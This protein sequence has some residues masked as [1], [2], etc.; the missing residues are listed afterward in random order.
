MPT[1]SPQLPFYNSMLR[2]HSII[3]RGLEITHTHSLQFSQNGFPNQSTQ[4][5]FSR[6][7]HCLLVVLENHHQMEEEI[8]FP[9][10]QD[11][12][13]SLRIEP[14]IEQHKQMK[15]H[16]HAVKTALE[17][18]NT[19]LSPTESLSQLADASSKLNILWGM[20]A[21]A[22]EIYFANNSMS[23]FELSHEEQI[24]I[25]R[26]TSEHSQK[27]SNPPQWVVPF[28]L[29]NLPPDEREQMAQLMPP[30]ISKMIVPMVWKNEW[31]PMKPFFFD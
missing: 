19:G 3:T 11:R 8:A 26:R 7:V 25:T 10:F 9:Y 24:A 27:N 29:Y 14:I 30:H 18:F 1:S 4:V 15:P 23:A 6:Y 2:I 17:Q 31:A 20:H 21:P 5:G 12:L 13:P 22:E 28:L 16:I